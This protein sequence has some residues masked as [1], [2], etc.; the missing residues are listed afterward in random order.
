MPTYTPGKG[1]VRR[2]GDAVEASQMMGHADGG[3]ALIETLAAYTLAA[4][5]ERADDFGKTVFPAKSF[6][7]TEPLC[8][9][10][11]SKTLSRAANF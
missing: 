2:A 3:A 8:E 11:R 5:G 4:N 1:L 6:S 10:F 7:A 9:F